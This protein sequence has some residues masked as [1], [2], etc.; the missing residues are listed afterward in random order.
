MDLLSHLGIFPDGIVGHSLGEL[1][2]AYADGCFTAEQAVLAAYSRGKAIMESKL[3]TGAMAAVGLTWEQAKTRCPT[4]IYPACHNAQDSVSISGPVESICKF[5]DEL[6]SEGIFAKVVQSSGQAFHS[7]YI[8]PAGPKLRKAL[9]QIIPEPKPRSKKWI[10]SSIPEDK[11]NSELA[12]WSGP[13][14]HVNNFL[15]QVLFQEALAHVPED[16]LVI[17]IA[18]HCLLQAILKRSLGASCIN[19]GLMSRTAPDNSIYFLSSIGKIFIGGQNPK[20][21]NLFD[22]VSFPVTLGTPMISSMVKWDHSKSWD[23]AKF[24]KV[25]FYNIFK[26][27]IF[28][29]VVY[30]VIIFRALENRKGFMKSL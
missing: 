11:W 29:G 18:P 14:Y 9:E 16:A 6:K 12:H 3:Q 24:D 15:S 20:I 30:S 27:W 2:C 25:H 22:E 23:I 17:E 19:V 21:A 28:L 8:A 5:V 13:D 7:K 1:G 10:S 26:E 4:D